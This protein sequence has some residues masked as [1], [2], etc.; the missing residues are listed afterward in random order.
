MK[1]IKYTAVTL[2]Q[3]ILS[4]IYFTILI[5]L[6]NNKLGGNSVAELIF[7]LI[8]PA[9]A[10]VLLC[11]LFHRGNFRFQKEN[12]KSRASVT[13]L[14]V[15]LCVIAI[16]LIIEAILEVTDSA[17]RLSGIISNAGLSNVI[18]DLVPYIVCNFNVS[19]AVSVFPI[20]YTVMEY[21]FTDVKS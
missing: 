20:V 18:P 1:T 17:N 6:F 4:A 13:R 3:I 9:A 2:G 7:Y 19:I 10:A 12:T 5:L 11:F 15:R 14:L 21:L 16:I 8:L